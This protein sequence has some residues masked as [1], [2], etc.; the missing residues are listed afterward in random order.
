MI[1]EIQPQQQ[2]KRF[3]IVFD[4]VKEVALNLELMLDTQITASVVEGLK[5]VFQVG[6]F[7]HLDKKSQDLALI[8]LGKYYPSVESP[9]RRIITLGVQGVAHYCSRFGAQR[10]VPATAAELELYQRGATYCAHRAWNEKY[11]RDYARRFD[12]GTD[13]YPVATHH[14]TNADLLGWAWFSDRP[15]RDPKTGLA[16]LKIKPICFTRGLKKCNSLPTEKY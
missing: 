16:C 2:R 3:R 12:Q 10:F 6:V 7:A 13:L 5:Q 8:L 14:G 1:V 9:D 4:S 15:T 11:L